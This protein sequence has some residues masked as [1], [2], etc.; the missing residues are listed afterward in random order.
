MDIGVFIPINNNGRIVSVA[1]PQYIPS[2]ERNK[3]IVL[4]GAELLVPLLLDPLV[5]HLQRE[6]GNTRPHPQAIAAGPK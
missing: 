5:H 6:Q 1:S 3:K 2:L 4:K